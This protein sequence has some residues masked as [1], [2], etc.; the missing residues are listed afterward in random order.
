MVVG[1]TGHTN[2]VPSSPANPSIHPSNQPTEPS[3]PSTPTIAQ[4][5]PSP[6]LG[7]CLGGKVEDEEAREQGLLD[8]EL[9][10]E[11]LPLHPVQVPC[12]C[13]VCG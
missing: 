7:T 5:N 10:H 8:A 3:P 6:P 11:A 2:H 9:P 12:V 13:A 4:P 1:S